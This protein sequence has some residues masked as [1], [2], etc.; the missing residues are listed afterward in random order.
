MTGA[1][2]AIEAA[3]VSHAIATQHGPLEVV[4]DVSLSVEPGEFVAIVGPSGGG[5]TTFLNLVAGLEQ[6]QEGT[7][8]VDGRAPHAGAPGVSYAFARDALLAWRTIVENVAL[9][10]ELAGVPLTERLCRARVQLKRVGLEDYAE[11]FRSQLSQGMRQRVALAR[12]LVNDPRLLLMDEPFA[13]LDVQTRLLMQEQLLDVLREHNATVLFVTHDL[14]EAIALA[15]RV[16][17]FTRR[18]ARIKTFY[19]ID[20]PR[21]RTV[22]SLQGDAAYHRIY[23]DLWAQLRDEVAAA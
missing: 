7:L 21:P 3:H 23:E 17:L 19:A 12:T 2:A 9:P 20:L 22:M 4:R 14:G 13:A 5:K 8:L 6:P 10:L 15:D 11:H 16:V 18:P 1:G